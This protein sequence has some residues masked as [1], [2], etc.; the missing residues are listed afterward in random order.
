MALRRD[1][2]GVTVYGCSGTSTILYEVSGR[3]CH[4][5]RRTQDA[6][7]FIAPIGERLSRWDYAVDISTG[8]SPTEFY[9]HR[10]HK[11]FRTVSLIR[12]DTGETVY[13]GSAKS[14][15]FCRVYRYSDPHPRA[16]LLRVEFVFKRGL[17]KHAAELF[18]QSEDESHFLAK[19]GNTYGWKHRDWQVD[20]P[21]DERIAAP[22]TTQKEEDTVAW[23]YRQVA[24][25]MRRLVK[26]GALDMTDFLQ[27]IYGQVDTGQ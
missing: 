23:M 8:T 12:S 20:N 9:N 16:H 22:S 18:C 26:V 24:P 25:A 7:E 21:T 10:S 6:R 13:C 5:I 11:N 17:A 27:F 3:A 15:R 19:L 2:N 14:D 1:D 4:G